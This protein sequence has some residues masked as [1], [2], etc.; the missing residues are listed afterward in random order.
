MEKT[1]L[2]KYPKLL[3]LFITFLIAYLLFYERAYP[4]FHDFIISIG[5]AGTFIAGISF[6]YGFTAAPATAILL[7]IS[8]EQNLIAAGLIGGLGALVADLFIFSFIRISFADEIER[9]SNEKIIKTFNSH[10]PS[11][12]KRYLLPVFAGLI[13]A[14]PLPDEIGVTMLAAS[15]II[16]TKI[17]TIVSYILNTAGIFTILYVGKMIV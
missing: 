7:L 10:L 8:K 13:I 1:P 12:I 6:A 2:I 11:H 4:P 15:K 16:S 3:L 5:Y 14:S 17:F 9:I